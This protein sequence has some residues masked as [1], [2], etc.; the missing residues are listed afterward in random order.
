VRRPLAF[1]GEIEAAELALVD[2]WQRVRIVLEGRPRPHWWIVPIETVSQSESGFE[3]VYQGSAILAV[4]KIE[5]PA[6]RDI[7]CMLRVEISHLD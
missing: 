1:G 7:S 3:R 6:W 2:E 4:W 5:P